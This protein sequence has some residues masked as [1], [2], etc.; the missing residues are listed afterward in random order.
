M[1]LAFIAGL[2]IWEILVILVVALIVFGPRLPEVAKSLG[3]GYMEFRKG[4]RSLE[5]E[6]EFGEADIDVSRPTDG[7]APAQ[8]GVSPEGPS[9]EEIE[10]VPPEESATDPQSREK[11][12]PG[13][14][15]EKP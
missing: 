1:A 9:G 14:G 6:L 4:L 12:K 2:G 8:P 11:A 3:K 15:K 5:S 13:E 7:S 10:T